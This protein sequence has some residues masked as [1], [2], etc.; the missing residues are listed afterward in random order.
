M[1]RTAR[2]KR[3]GHTALQLVC[4]WVWVWLKRNLLCVALY[5]VESK[6]SIFHSGPVLVET[7]RDRWMAHNTEAKRGRVNTLCE[8]LLSSLSRRI[9]IVGC[10]RHKTAQ[11]IA[12]IDLNQTMRTTQSNE[13]T[14]RNLCSGY[15][16][17]T[18]S[19]LISL[20]IFDKY[21]E[22]RCVEFRAQLWYSYG[23]YRREQTAHAHLSL[24]L[25]LCHVLAVENTKISLL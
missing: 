21:I 4:V 9:S 16:S 14:K 1:C 18:I 7:D 11:H 3:M 20:H 10:Q 5:A 19:A 12:G 15:L 13:K 23:G 24:S 6:W 8:H 2:T 25:S 22:I 17:Y